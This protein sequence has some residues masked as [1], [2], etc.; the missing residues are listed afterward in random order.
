MK[1]VK[2]LILVEN[3]KN[4]LLASRNRIIASQ[5]QFHLKLDFIFD[6]SKVT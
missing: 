3:K 1:N 2:N 5:K 4:M 6:L